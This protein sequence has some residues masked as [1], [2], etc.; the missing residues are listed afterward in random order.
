MVRIETNNFDCFTKDKSELARHGLD[1]PAY[2]F[3]VTTDSKVITLEFPEF[4]S[5]DEEVWCYDLDSCA[6]FSI[7]MNGAA[8]LSG[9]WHDLTA[10]QAMSIPFVSAEQLEITVDGD[11]HTLF[12]DHENQTYRFDDIDVTAKNNEDASKNFEYLYASVSEIKHDVFRDDVPESMGE[13]TCIFRYTLTDGTESEL[14]LVPIDDETYWAYTD[15]TCLGMTVSRSAITGS[16]GCLSF[17]ERL[18][19]DLN[20]TGN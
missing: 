12:I 1:N 9:K 2:T 10:K 17:I 4:N 3:T 19:N 20:G 7:T 6:V 15:G 18:T 14:A 16:N 13:P 8:F 11:T 5:D